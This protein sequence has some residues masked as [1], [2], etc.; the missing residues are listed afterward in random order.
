MISKNTAKIAISIAQ[1]FDKR[2]LVLTAV[3]GTPLAALVN[4][5]NMC[6]AVQVNA[7]NEYE[8]NAGS[9]EG[10]SSAFDGAVSRHDE[11]LCDM[12]SDISKAVANHLN[13][14][15]NV[16]RPVI[17]EL[18]TEVEA[19]IAALP[20][21]IQYNLEVV[22]IDPPEPMI[23]TAFE[24]MVEEFSEVAYSPI[25]GYMGLPAKSAPEVI[26]L[27]TTGY[28]ETDEAIAVWTA[29]KGDSFFQLVW[30]SV[31]T[32]APTQERF[33]S[34]IQNNDTG[35]DAAITVFLLCKRLYDNPPESTAMALPK[36]NEQLA[37]LRN[38]AA[39]RIHHGYEEHVRNSKLG[40]LIRKVTTA[41]LFVNGNVYRKWM[42]EGGNNA[43]LFGSILSDRPAKFASDLNEKKSEFLQIWEQHN[44]LLT[45]TERNKRFVN[46]KNILRSRTEKVIGDNLTACFGEVAKGQ[47]VSTSLPE[48]IQCMAELEKHID[49]VIEAD[50]KNL[51]ALCTKLICHCA[52]YYTDAGKILSGIEKACQD[53]PGIEIREAALLSLVEYVTDYVCDQM[54]LSGA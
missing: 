29:K 37:E 19:D 6:E 12:S 34:M 42:E 44:S 28:K 30:D 54:T 47:E 15:K 16:V 3:P 25:T 27:L 50:F 20:L 31:F 45:V 4:S 8:P 49:R 7:P 39:L 10:M 40:L 41:A 21:N 26:E 35:I 24:E 11:E 36:Y 14:A 17:Q 22:V 52:F 33:E 38:Q 2:N 9:I 13:F 32:A 5:C 23:S 1:E 51:W 43:A 18:V 46:Y 48:Y 53:N